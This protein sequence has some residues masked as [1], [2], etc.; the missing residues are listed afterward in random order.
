MLEFVDND[1]EGFPLGAPHEMGVD[2]GSGDPA[3]GGVLGVEF[4]FGIRADFGS[5]DGH[6]QDVIFGAEIE[7]FHVFY[8]HE[9]AGSQAGFLTEFA[10]GG[11]DGGFG[12]AVGE[13]FDAAV[14]NLPRALVFAGLLGAL[15]LQEF[16]V[17]FLVTID[18]DGDAIGAD[19]GHGGSLMMDEYG[20]ILGESRGFEYEGGG[21]KEILK[22]SSEKLTGF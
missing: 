22:G 10:Q 17:V 5:E 8:L 1:G 12:F 4:D 21:F 16:Q 2:L 9:V 15:D 11:L 7:G 14:D 6:E 18:V 13:G 3:E 20:L 19:F